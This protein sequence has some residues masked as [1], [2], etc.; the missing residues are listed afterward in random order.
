[1]NIQNIQIARGIAAILV[2][3]THTN[4]IINKSLFN[5][6]LIIGWSGVDLFF[7]LSGFIIFLTNQKHFEN[8]S[9]LK[10]YLKKRIIRVIP[11]YWACLIIFSF[12]SY[13]M[14]E[15]YSTTVLFI[16]QPEGFIEGFAK[17]FLLCPTDI[18]SNKFPMLPVAWTL[19]YELMFYLLFATCF[20][21]SRRIILI[22]VTIWLFLITARISNILEVSFENKF[23]YIITEP[24]NIE[25]LLGCLAAYIFTKDVIS[26]RGRNILII[27]GL[28]TL[29]IAWI[30]TWLDF[31]WF[32]KNIAIQ[33]GFPYFLITLAIVKKENNSIHL[34]PAKKFFTLAGDASYSIYL[35]HYPLILILVFLFRDTGINEYSLFFC[36]LAISI[37]FGIGFYKSIEQPLIKY[38]KQIILTKNSKKMR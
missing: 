29:T 15:R 8:K 25:F 3:I 35:T 21:L 11:T 22:T 33:F 19:T 12:A 17:A 34:S 32:D 31:R 37:L 6:L 38:A 23:F 18:H 36:F 30:N 7:V 16:H 2:L 5:E 28:S 27:L 4:L 9:Y 26:N 24:R 20:F 10:I 1:M 14:I 13:V